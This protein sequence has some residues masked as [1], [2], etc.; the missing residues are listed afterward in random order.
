MA[1]R[2]ADYCGGFPGLTFPAG[3]AVV[4]PPGGCEHRLLRCGVCDGQ[5]RAAGFALPGVRRPLAASRQQLQDQVK[6]IAEPLV[7]GRLG[8]DPDL[9]YELASACICGSDASSRPRQK[10]SRTY[11]T[12]RPARALSRGFSARAGPARQP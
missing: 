6:L 1:G 11:G 9:S 3:I 8:Q 2:Q 10:L 5:W 12:G 7:A 4:L